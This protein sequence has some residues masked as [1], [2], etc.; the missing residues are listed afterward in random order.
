MEKGPKVA[1]IILF[2]I[3]LLI[4]AAA[5]ILPYLISLDRYK[6]MIEA[7]L[8]KTLQREVSLGGVRITI[9]PTLGAKIEDLVIANPPGFSPTPFFSLRDVTIKV[10]L[11]PLLAGRKEIAG[12]TLRY[13]TIFIERDKK[14]K[15]NIPFMDKKISA[16]R[17]GKLISGRVKVEKSKALQGLSLSRVSLKGVKF[18]Y[19]DQSVTPARRTEIEEID[20]EVKDLSLDKRIRYDLFFKQ[21]GGDISVQGCLGPLGKTLDLK[22]IPVEGRLRAD[23][24]KLGDLMVMLTGVKEAALQGAFKADLNFSGDIG[25]ALKAQG[26]VFLKAFSLGESGEKVIQNLNL[27]LRP[28]VDLSWETGMLKLKSALQIEKTPFHIEGEFR[29]LQREPSGKLTFSSK[30]SIHLE[31][32]APKFPALQKVAKLKG[33]IVLKGAFRIPPQG[34]P[35]LSL[36]ANSSQ[37]EIALAQEKKEKGEKETPQKKVVKSE[38]QAPE[39]NRLDVDGK[40]KVKEGKFEEVDFRDLLLVGEMRGGELKIKRFSLAAFEGEL[41]GSGMLNRGKET[42]PFQI[43]THI[44]GVDVDTV[45][46]DLTSWKGMMQGRLYGQMSL[47]GRELSLASLKKDLTG[48]GTVRIRDGELSWLNIVGPIVQ[49]LGGKG[50]EKEKTVFE[51]LSTSFTV[52]RG[53][54]SLPDLLLSHKDMEIRMWGNIGLDLQ[55]HMEGEAHLPPSATKDLSGKVWR[56]LKDEAGRLTIPFTLRGDIKNPEVGISTRFIERGLEGAFEELLRKKRH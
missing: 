28:E 37:M 25:S 2:T 33:D 7:R 29:D 1:A 48:K 13:P 4:I 24:P 35:L 44:T 26:E 6:G 20:V 43:K 54:V 45:L 32:W 19:L 31:D 30:E 38:E 39:G 15:L 23:F 3:F 5:F 36:E 42:P 49:A 52:Q 21:A 55:L 27:S 46:S 41:E 16:G 18:V 51:D 17:R 14:G 53:K 34:T 56:Y 8:E 50:W 22:S 11:F 40:L 10:R 47:R 12:L 9:L